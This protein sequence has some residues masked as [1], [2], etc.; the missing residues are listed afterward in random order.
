MSETFKD[1][2]IK[3]LERT[4]YRGEQNL[5]YSKYILENKMENESSEDRN[6]VQLNIDQQEKNVATTKNFLEWLKNQK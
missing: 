1:E 6:K 2:Y 4:V 5:M 3:E